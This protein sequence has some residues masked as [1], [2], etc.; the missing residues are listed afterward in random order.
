MERHPKIELLRS[1]TVL[2]SRIFDVVEEAVR[3]PSGLEQNLVVVDH[4]GAVCVAPLLESGELLLVR[5]Y[6]HAAGD[7]M[8]EV[9]AGRLERH[10]DPET[11]ARRELE[12]ETGQRAQRWVALETFYTAPGFCSERMTL[13]LATGLAEV[14][15]GGL[16]ADDD[17]EIDL[18]RMAPRDLIAGGNA[19]AKT[20]LAAA[21]LIARGLA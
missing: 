9:P 2:R 7:W 18:V 10:E 4:P 8:V 6:R 1:E 21:V 14:P 16:A 5:Q 3:L 19:D 12:E 11:A 15:G 20:I 17:E 13:F